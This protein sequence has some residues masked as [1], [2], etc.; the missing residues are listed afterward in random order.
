MVHLLRVVIALAVV[1]VLAYLAAP[2]IDDAIYV[3]RLLTAERPSR[4]PLPVAGV[5][6]RAVRD[7]WGDPR[8]GDRRHE[9]VDIFARRGTPVVSTTRGLISSIGENRLGGT[10]VWVMG[11]GGDL[12]YYA[13]L[14]RVAD[15]EP[16][17]RVEAG[18][19]IGYVGNSGNAAATAPHLH[20]GIYRRPGGAINPYPLLTAP[21][22]SD[23]AG[24]ARGAHDAR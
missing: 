24:S 6:L 20:Y 16:R 4:L 2:W 17:Q 13:H 21:L 14:D 8:P 11:P 19:V 18:D 22:A 9:G 3:A 23:D 1:G 5:S 7:S 15:I 12:H 10:V